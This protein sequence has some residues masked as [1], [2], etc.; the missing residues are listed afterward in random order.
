[1]AF[2]FKVYQIIHYPFQHP[3]VEE[4]DEYQKKAEVSSNCPDSSENDPTLEKKAMDQKVK[5]QF[6]NLKNLQL[7]KL[8][9]L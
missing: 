9:I 3:Y 7:K 5:K 6:K 1:M 2:N 8:D 4:T